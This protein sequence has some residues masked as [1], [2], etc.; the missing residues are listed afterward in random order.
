MGSIGLPGIL[1]AL[2]DPDLT[3]IQKQELPGGNSWSPTSPENRGDVGVAQ[4]GGD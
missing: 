4:D 2:A 1:K 3:L